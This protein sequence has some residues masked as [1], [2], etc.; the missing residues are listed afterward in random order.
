MLKYFYLL[1]LLAI[2]LIPGAFAQTDDFTDAITNEDEIVA[3]ITPTSPLYFLDVLFD[4]IS[5]SFANAENGDKVEVGL[6][7]ANERLAEEKILLLEQRFDLADQVRIEHEV[8]LEEIRLALQKIQLDDPEDELRLKIEIE[9]RIDEHGDKVEKTKTEIKIRMAGNIPEERLMFVNSIFAGIT[10]RTGQIK[11]M[12]KIETDKTEIK[13][14][15]VNFSRA[16]IARLIAE[17]GDDAEIK[18][19]IDGDR[20][21]LKIESHKR[22]HIDFSESGSNL[23]QLGDTDNRSEDDKSDDS[24]DEVQLESSTNEKQGSENSGSGYSGG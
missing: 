15:G 7:I 2:I 4:N 23:F 12:I 1:P 10:E 16:D 5:F 20:L 13:L 3:G 19:K 6:K 9:K 14:E 11:I 17:A 8:K 18:L 22:E 24:D 21:K